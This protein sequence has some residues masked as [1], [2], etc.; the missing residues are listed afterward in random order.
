MDPLKNAFKDEDKIATEAD[1]SKIHSQQSVPEMNSQGSHFKMDFNQAAQKSLGDSSKDDPNIA[2]QE[3]TPKTV[4]SRDIRTFVSPF[5]EGCYTDFFET[6]RAAPPQGC[7]S[8][9]NVVSMG[10]GTGRKIRAMLA[11]T[12]AA[13]LDKL[14]AHFF[15]IDPEPAMLRRGQEVLDVEA[16]GQ[17]R[18]I[19]DVEWIAS[20]ALSFTTDVPALCG[21]T[22]L[23]FFAGG[24]FQH[25]L[26]P[27]EILAFLRQVARALQ[28]GS[29]TATAVLVILGESLPS[30]MASIPNFDAAPIS[31]VSERRPELTYED[32]KKET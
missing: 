13:G 28:T 3:D 26:S 27:T 11:Q 5:A 14:D 12:Q 8:P 20:D 32:V 15:A 23:L 16:G 10:S 22:D 21:A 4:V 2:F 18:K 29:T 17:P 1:A 7:I 25:L 9:L 19:A 24:G 6:P 31:L 30:K